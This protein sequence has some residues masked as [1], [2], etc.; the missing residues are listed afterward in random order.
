MSIARPGTH[1]RRAALV[2]LL[3][4]AT[5]AAQTTQNPPPAPAQPP[6]FDTAVTVTTD[7]TEEKQIDAPSS[8]VQIT[9]AQLA[10]RGVTTLSDA[11]ALIPGLEISAGADGG[12]MTSGV[13]LWGLREF[14]A[15][16]LF[17]DGV[18][19]GGVYNPNTA[20]V[21]V[22]NIERIEVVKGPNAVLYGQTAFAGIIQ[23]FTRTARAGRRG[24]MTFTGGTLGTAGASGALDFIQGDKVWRL[25]FLGRTS[26]GWQPRA[27]DRQER[28]DLT[29]GKPLAAGAGQLKIIGR[30]LDRTQGFGAPFP[31][32][33]AEVAPGVSIDQNYAV[34]DARVA[35]RIVMGT[36]YVDRPLG[37]LA[38]V[39]TSSVSFDSQSRIRSFLSSADPI[40]EAQGS[41]LSPEQLDIF[42]DTHVEWRTTW[43]GRPSLLQAGGGYQFGR[44]EAEARL[45]DYT[46]SLAN[47]NPPSSTDLAGEEAE[48][49]NRR[50]FGGA[51]V[52]E[53][54][55]VTDRLTLAGGVRVDFTRE[56]SRVGGDKP[57]EEATTDQATHAAPSYRAAATYR[58]STAGPVVASVYGS[59]N[60]AFKPAA[61]NFGEPESQ[62]PILEPEK[63]DAGEG[64]VKI[65]TTDGRLSLQASVF[66]MNFENLVVSQV[67]NGL[68]VYA[69]AGAERFR[70]VELDGE[71][72]PAV[73]SPLRLKLGYAFHNPIFTSYTMTDDDGAPIVLDG[74]RLELAPKHLWNAE[75]DYLP[76]T[77]LGAF[78]ALRGAG[79]RPVNRRN[80]AF[81]D[82][83]A[84]VDLGASY[85]IGRY[86]FV[87][88]ILN[89]SDSRHIIAE[90]ELADAQVYLNPPRR[91]TLELHV[92]F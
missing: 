73:G 63:A 28:V 59:F 26:D 8:V 91:G 29:F 79:A 56:H 10:A 36:V 47:P 50:D 45:F 44:L 41:A 51:Y 31:R 33:G 58:L 62:G 9:G 27:G 2:L 92:T 1:A 86:R 12:P 32:A 68:V 40:A 22:E 25:S 69:N 30:V 78:A 54:L 84:V 35:D 6:R 90:S 38:F 24:A 16:A 71:V 83:Y 19:A 60:H 43:R 66:Q 55:G 3:S 20:F 7:R 21:P 37:R 75:V 80:S 48:F 34:T 17:I 88:T 61:V 77:G 4:A 89:V 70:G 64:G 14:D 67:E 18:P 72:A 85:A 65:A 13:A 76:E 82:P 57:G 15:Y 49:F 87:G 74:N 81:T 11:L 39:S 23:V 52:H 46:V 5:A 53:Q 42:E